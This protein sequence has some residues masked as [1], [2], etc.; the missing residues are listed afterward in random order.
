MKI[1]SALLL[2]LI[3]TSYSAAQCSER[4]IVVQV[5]GVKKGPIAD[6][7]AVDFQ[8]KM[9]GHPVTIANATRFRSSHRIFILVDGSGSMRGEAWSVANAISGHL[10]KAAPQNSALG[11]GVI[12]EKKKRLVP[13]GVNSRAEILQ[14]IDDLKGQNHF[15]EGATPLIDAVA[16]ATNWFVPPSAGDELVVIT[17]GF[18]NA[19]DKDILSVAR[20]MSAS[21]IRVNVILLLD[22]DTSITSFQKRMLQ[23]VSNAF[24]STGGRTVFINPLRFI[25][26]QDAQAQYRAA[27]ASLVTGEGEWV[28]SVRDVP[29]H[30]KWST[31]TVDIADLHGKSR[32]DVVV[33]F[34]RW[35]APCP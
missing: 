27:A 8:A 32:H 16:N 30:D 35:W 26:K 14:A 34:P 19:S 20:Q 1:E 18:D 9:S 2:L 12:S 25:K 11:L 6:V 21:G 17:D 13:F 15:P 28:L 23:T 4:D 3:A 24:A 29:R 22:F 5:L 31:W 33:D 10:V 7:N